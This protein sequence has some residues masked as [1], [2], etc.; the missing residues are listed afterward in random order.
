MIA[1]EAGLMNAMADELARRGMADLASRLHASAAEVRRLEVAMD[2]IVNDAA[3]DVQE[4]Q[5]AERLAAAVR[6]GQ[7]VYLDDHRPTRLR[8][9]RGAL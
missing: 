2:G 7:V 6:A 3:L 8:I 5:T 4:A 9:V 1:T